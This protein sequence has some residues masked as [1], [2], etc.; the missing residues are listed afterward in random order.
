MWCPWGAAFELPEPMPEVFAPFFKRLLRDKFDP[1]KLPPAALAWLDS[2]R[3][4][5]GFR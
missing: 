5:K 3:L 4:K 2:L 1:D